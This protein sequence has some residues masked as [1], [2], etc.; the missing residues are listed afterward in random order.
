MA[1][2]ECGNSPSIPSRRV[3]VC[4]SPLLYIIEDNDDN[5]LLYEWIFTRHLRTITFHLF[6]DG[7]FLRSR[8]EAARQKPD[9]IL[10]DLKMPYISGLELLVQLKQDPHWKDIPVI[11][12]THS[13]SEREREAC[14]QAGAS[15]FIHK[16]IS[17]HG[18][19]AQLEDVCQVWL[20]A[21]RFTV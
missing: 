2:S 13:T 1:D 4:R 8:L 21:N 20:K 7:T 11:I 18:I 17:V 3:A 5:L 9:L 10:L 14:F 6:S 12:Y 15:G 16:E 19:R